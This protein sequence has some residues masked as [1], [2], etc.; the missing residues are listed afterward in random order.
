MNVFARNKAIAA[1]MIL[2]LAA[3]ACSNEPVAKPQTSAET[4]AKKDTLVIAQSTETRD[5]TDIDPL[6]KDITLPRSMVFDTL[7]ERKADGK[8]VPSLAESF[9]VNG[10]TVHIQLKKNISFHSGD[11]LTAD[12]VKATLE[13]ILDKNVT[14]SYKSGF[15]GIDQIKVLNDLAIDIV[16]KQPNYVLPN[17]LAEMPVLSAK[18]LAAGDEYKTKLNGTGPYVL[19]DWKRGEL[20]SLKLNDKYWGEKPAFAKVVVK[21]VADESTRIAELLSGK[22]DIA[23]DISP[24]SLERIKGQKGFQAVS[25]PGVR[26]TWLSYHFKAPFDNKKVRQAI[27]KAIDRKGLAQNLYGDFASPATAPVIKGGAGYVE[28]YP[29]TDFNLDEAKK[30]IAESGIQTPVTIDLDARKVDLD[31]AQIVQAQL[32]KIGIEAKINTIDAGAFF[33]P[34]RFEERKSGSI[35]LSTSFDN[36]EKETYRLLGTAYSAESFYKRYGYQPL[37]EADALVKQYIAEPKAENRTELA[38]NVLQMSKEDASVLWLMHPSNIYGISDALDWKPDGT[39]RVE[40]RQ[41]KV[42]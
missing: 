3:A 11:P 21:N 37:P 4:P 17:F 36:P 20:V 35:M 23:S 34:K 31:I 18:Q 15:S 42:K 7:F 30:L 32:K 16:S 25:E 40:I 5:L 12:S 8:L 26:V 9:E 19:E 10:N 38:K 2:S 33:D 28:A 14:T 6:Q 1:L 13:K 22:A 29:L 41:I 27:Y 39:G 24:A